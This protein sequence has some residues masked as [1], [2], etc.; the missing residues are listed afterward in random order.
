MKSVVGVKVINHNAETYKDRF[1]GILYEF[2]PKKSI[3]IPYEAACHIFGV[4]FAPGPTGH[5]NPNIREK[6][7]EHIH[8]RWGWN[9]PGTPEQFEKTR[10][11][12]KKRFEAIEFSIVHMQMVETSTDEL[13]APKEAA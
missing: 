9:K 6:A 8:K 11:A 10:L 7:F 4:D 12:A 13:P 5:I 1:D 2:A 3:T